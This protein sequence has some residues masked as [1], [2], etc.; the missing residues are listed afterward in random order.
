MSGYSLLNGQEADS[1]EIFELS[2]FEVRA[3]D[4]YVATNSVSGTKFASDLRDTPLTINVL[5]REFLDD[6]NSDSLVQSLQFTSGVSSQDGYNATGGRGL[7][8]ENRLI[9]R[10]NAVRFVYRN[11]VRSWRGD[12]P[13]FIERIEVLKGPTAILYG[14]SLPGGTLNYIT[15]KPILGSTGGGVD[16][17]VDSFGG[18]EAKLD[19]YHSWGE[20]IGVRLAGVHRG[21]D[22]FADDEERE[23]FNGMAALTYKPWRRTKLE[24]DY[25]RTSNLVDNVVA[26]G[27][28]LWRGPDAEGTVNRLGGEGR[29]IG[30]HPLASVTDN[31]FSDEFFDSF[32]D[33]DSEIYSISL[34]QNITEGMDLRLKHT[35]TESGYDTFRNF[36]TQSEGNSMLVVDEQGNPISGRAGDTVVIGGNTFIVA[37]RDSMAANTIPNAT[38]GMWFTAFGRGGGEH[39]L[40]P[41]IYESRGSLLTFGNDFTSPSMYNPNRTAGYFDEEAR[42]NEDE[43]TQLEF[44]S[45]FEIGSTSHR[46]LVGGERGRTAF[47]TQKIESTTIPPAYLL[48][49]WDISL[50]QA[51]DIYGRPVETSPLITD[52]TR[53]ELGEGSTSQ[54]SGFDA[55]YLVYTGTLLGDRLNVLGGIRFEEA[56]TTEEEYEVTA[57]QAGVI[58]DL[59]DELSLYASYSESF[60][61]NNRRFTLSEQIAGPA[62]AYVPGALFPPE[63]G[64]GIDVGI[65]FELADGRVNGNM[66]YFEIQH[67]NISVPNP[68]VIDV[69]G[70]PVTF[71]DG[72]NTTEGVELEMFYTATDKLQMTIGL[73]YIDAIIE[74]GFGASLNNIAQID[75]LEGTRL[76]DSSKWHASVFGRYQATDSMILGGGF[77]YKSAPAPSYD[78]PPDFTW[79]SSVVIN[80]F[81]RYSTRFLEH[82]VTIGVNINNLFDEE[83]YTGQSQGNPG[84]NAKL[85]LTW[86]F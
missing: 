23:Q 80:V 82:P 7:N 16:V 47:V 51:V 38:P 21:G 84:L 71:P 85:N 43:L 33:I 30:L 26:N 59:T 19:F 53:Q 1:G 81:A 48:P 61:L 14:Q 17:G 78:L 73:S 28:I 76:P 75:V 52:Y 3:V 13:F 74:K 46:F 70:N 63:E 57:P 27:T 32:I 10:G 86:L 4:G 72:I 22:T 6:L 62:N 9:M 60:R 58:Y 18:F 66:T 35:Y 67:E 15:K 50:K 34:E 36:F 83:Y 42:S 54:R 40:R 49:A 11:G 41:A 24:V 65:K 25:T 79:G 77:V 37:N 39:A 56:F 69:S 45:A 44:T 68:D 8:G 55:G 2:P 64:I 12:E 31:P 29:S 20:T 5:T